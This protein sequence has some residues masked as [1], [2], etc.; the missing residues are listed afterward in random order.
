[1]SEKIFRHTPHRG[2]DAIKILAGTKTNATIRDLE[3]TLEDIE[4]KEGVVT[5]IDKDKINGDGWSVKDEDGKTYSCNCSSDMYQLP[6]TEEYGGMYYPKDKVKVKFTINPVLGTNTITEILSL[7][8]N[9]ES[10]DLSKWKHGDKSTTVIAKPKSAI[11]ISDAIISFNYNN[12]NKVTADKD[13]VKTD[14]KKTNINTETLQINSN[15]IKIRDT[16][17]DDYLQEQVRLADE[18]SQQKTEGIDILHQNNMGQLNLNIKSV[19]IPK[20]NEKVIKDLKDPSLYPESRQRH[21]LLTGSEIDELYIYPN[22]LVTVKARNIPNKRDIFSTHNWIASANSYK[23]L[24]IIDAVRFCDCCPES[25]NGRQT[26]FNYCP[27]CKTWNTLYNKN[28][29]IACTACSNTWCP[30]CGHT[31]GIECSNKIYD[32]KKYSD[33]NI[34]AIGLECNYCKNEVPS[35][36]NREYANYCP[37]CHRWNYLT[38]ETKY[39]NGNE[40]RFLHCDYCGEFY[41]VNCSISQGKSFI[42][43]F[44]NDNTTYD[45]QTFTKNFEKLKYIRD[46]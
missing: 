16:S 6:E 22:G 25:I 39:D 1:M 5:S 33:Y 4:E 35:G 8:K 11:S 3:E 46:D 18:Y 20:D 21:P 38:L 42:K 31:T 13:E 10:I 41:C 26:Y 15:K 44:L 23:N 27:H 29:L 14:G 28:N 36:K 40:R 43:N 12:D 2:A 7:G 45:Y 30:A 17:L 32:L 19:F 37:K 9:E 24:I 34:S